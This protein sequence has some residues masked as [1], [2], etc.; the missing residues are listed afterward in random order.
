MLICSSNIL[1]KRRF[2]KEI[3][4]QES[5]GNKRN[6]KSVFL[7]ILPYIAKCYFEFKFY[8]NFNLFIL[9]LFLVYL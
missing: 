8:L 6:M 2:L 1:K 3:E 7:V 5:T 4:I 9:Y